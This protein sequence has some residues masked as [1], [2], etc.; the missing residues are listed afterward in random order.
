MLAGLTVCI[1]GACSSTELDR[2]VEDGQYVQAVEAFEADTSLALDERALFMAGVS[3]AVPGSEVRDPK[4]GRAL[5]TRL[6]ELYPDTEYRRE[7]DWLISF[8]DREAEILKRLADVSNTLEELKA[9]DLGPPPE[10]AS[11]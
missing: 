4:R 11:P 10:D 7:A 5:L 2:Y 1:S 3:Y 8:V 9:V 6:L